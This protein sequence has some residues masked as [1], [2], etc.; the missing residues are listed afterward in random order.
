M[1]GLLE[2]RQNGEFLPNPVGEMP[3][4]VLLGMI[5]MEICGLVSFL[6]RRPSSSLLEMKVE[7]RKVARPPPLKGGE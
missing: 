3:N 7:V 2:I 1:L 4:H 6:T 5:P